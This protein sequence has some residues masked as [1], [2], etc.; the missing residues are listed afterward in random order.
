M[1]AFVQAPGS[2]DELA[3]EDQKSPITALE[4]RSARRRRAEL[5][6]AVTAARNEFKA[7]RCRAATSQQILRRILS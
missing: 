5:I 4:K 3:P 7:G 6:E 1:R 2:A